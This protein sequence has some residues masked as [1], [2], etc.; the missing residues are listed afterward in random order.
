[1]VI[2]KIAAS[3]ALVAMAA[4]MFGVAMAIVTGP[5]RAARQAE[6]VERYIEAKCMDATTHADRLRWCERGG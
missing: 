5:E 2:E 1:M 4:G 6:R 3:I